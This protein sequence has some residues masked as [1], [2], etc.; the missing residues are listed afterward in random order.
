MN[1]NDGGGEQIRTCYLGTIM[2]LQNRVAQL[3]HTQQNVVAT[4]NNLPG[5]QQLTPMATTLQVLQCQLQGVVASLSDIRKKQDELD[6]Q[7]NILA[8]QMHMLMEQNVADHAK[9]VQIIID[10]Y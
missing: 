7:Q 3:E 10:H 2:A 1:P 5:Q 9:M 8:H 6:A 4:M